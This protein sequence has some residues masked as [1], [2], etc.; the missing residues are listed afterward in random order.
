MPKKQTLQSFIEKAT[1]V[2]GLTYSYDN[3]VYENSATKLLITCRVH[4]NF[5]QTPRDHIHSKAGC[6]TCAGN[7]RTDGNNIILKLKAVHGDLYDYSKVDT[8]SI[9][10]SQTVVSILCKQH[11]IFKQ[12]IKQHLRG[13]G[14]PTCGGTSTLTQQELIDRFHAAHGNS[15][16]Y[17]LVSYIS[18]KH[19]VDIVCNRHG[20]FSQ[21]PLIHANGHGCPKCANESVSK[22]LSKPFVRVPD[23]GF[24]DVTSPNYKSNKSKLQITC[25]QGHTFKRVASDYKRGYGC[26]SCSGRYSLE[27]LELNEFLASLG[28]DLQLNTTNVISPKEL[29]IYIPSKNIAIEYNGIYWHSSAF[30]DYKHRHLLK[31]NLCAERNVRVIHIWSD[32]WKYRRT[33]IEHALRMQLTAVSGLYARVC[34][35]RPISNTIAKPI[36]DTYHLQG[37]VPATYYGLFH[38]NICV[39]VMGFK[40]TSSIRG[41]RSSEGI[42]ELVRYVSTCRVIGGASK[43]LQHFIRTNSFSKLITY[44]DL[45]FFSGELYEAIGFTKVGTSAP[46]YKVIDP[47]TQTRKHKATTKR[48]N[49]PTLFGTSFNP[50]LSEFKNTQANGWYRVY[51]CGKAKY[52]L[53]L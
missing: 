26:P 1:T 17:S 51:D 29:D 3:A 24:A 31:S 39:A 44:C 34:T 52:E 30:P 38:N 15:Y 25:L 27:Q 50:D 37:Y 41:I 22:L 8:A 11:G 33:A 14:C 35:V 47:S 9:T 23:D 18:S 21:L 40:S 7:I 46:D 43:L 2:H 42:V 49:L 12:S 36:L 6:P 20:V 5:L 32:D 53:I 13:R 16:D 45:S 48:Q 4:G 19:K 10:S 28:L